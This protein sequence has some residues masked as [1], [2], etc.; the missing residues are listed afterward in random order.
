[1]DIYVEALSDD[2]E[3]ESVSMA[4]VSMLVHPLRPTVLVAEATASMSSTVSST[5]PA[6][7]PVG[8][9]LEHGAR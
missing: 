7:C 3:H 9:V 5:S 1:M 8:P 2:G 4:T 6:I